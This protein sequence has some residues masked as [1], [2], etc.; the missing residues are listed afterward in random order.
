M[1]PGVAPAHPHM[2]IDTGLT[3]FFDDDGRLSGVRVAW[4]YDDFSSLMIVEDRGYDDDADGVMTAQ[5]LD[6]FAGADVDWSSGFEGD[7]YLSVNGQPVALGPAE[8]F[9]A[10]YEQGYLASIHT[11][12]LATPLDVSAAPLSIKVYDPSFYAAYTVALPVAMAQGTPCEVNV[13]KADVKKA[14]QILDK[15]ISELPEDVFAEVEFPAVGE[16]YAD[17]IF[18]TCDAES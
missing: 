3:L 16:F 5:E 13:E 12:P 9:A 4:V 1:T 7:L 2:F 18:L 6:D 8:D 10:A 15:L 17:T 14:G 11:R